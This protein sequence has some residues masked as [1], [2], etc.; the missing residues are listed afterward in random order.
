MTG[1]ARPRVVLVGAGH[2]HLHLVAH[3]AR[4]R[5]AGA[6]VH[7]VDP[8][9]FWYSGLAT[10][11]LGGMYGGEEDRVDP[12]PLC[13]AAGVTY[14]PDR[15]VGV[16][17]AARTLRLASGRTLD[18]DLLSFNIGSEVPMERIPGAAEHAWSVKPV[19]NLW[20]LRRRLERAFRAGTRLRAVVIGGGETGCE[21]AANLRAL[22]ERRGARIAVTVLASG[23]RLL[24]RRPARA[25]RRLA[26][27]LRRRG[28]RLVLGER[29]AEVTAGEVRTASGTRLSADLAVCATGLRPPAALAA[30][31]LPTGPTGGL[32]VG[33]TLE[34]S[35]LPG[36]F[37]AGDCIDF[38]GRPL[39]RLGVHAVRQAPVLLHNLEAALRAGGG[40]EGAGPEAET[41]EGPEPRAYRPPAR[42]L[43]ILN[44]GDDRALALWGPLH[45]LGRGPL[46]LKDRIDRRF[47][48]GIREVAERAPEPLPSETAG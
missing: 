22:A 7:L 16:N 1:T 4:L 2:A 10:G 17:R 18:W 8:D 33:P 32:A 15:T 3:A 23:S 39:P 28:L 35:D 36:V 31:G 11:M 13:R 14:H 27:H 42:A 40:S 41:G 20:A 30:M 24:E 5:A 25:G 47:L 38:A 37:G 29:A 6:A 9:A 43:A 12:A 46:L 45:W 26:R 21:V 19:R 48:R 44:L 34:A